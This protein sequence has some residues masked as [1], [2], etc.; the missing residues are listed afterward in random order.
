M[1]GRTNWFEANP[2][3]AKLFVFVLGLLL[4]EGLVRVCV[5]AGLLPYR[6]YPTTPG[7][8]QYWAYIDPVVGVWRP[9]NATWHHQEKCIDATYHTNSIGARDKERSPESTAPRRVLVLGD[10]YLEGYGFN[11][12]A[13]TTN[14]LEDRT[15][16]EFMNFATAGGFGTIQE[17]LLYGSRA[18][19]Y[20]HSD[21]MLFVTP[22]NDF[23]DNDASD[24]PKKIYRPY[25]RKTGEGA[26]EV[27]Y[28]VP[29]EKRYTASRKRSTVIKNKID[30]SIYL[31]N[32][33][34]WATAE[35]KARTETQRRAFREAYYDR[36]DA[37]D[38]AVM[39]YAI[40]QLVKE[41][42]DRRVWL[43]T[44]P[45]D[46]DFYAA[47]DKGYHFPLVDEFK[48]YAAR[49]ANVRYLDLLP[50]FLADAKA[51]GLEFG[52]YTL[53]CDNHWGARGHALVADVVQDWMF[54]GDTEG[55]APP[56]KDKP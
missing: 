53:P 52:D 40:D 49:H 51:K 44:I 14:L 56:A 27:Y 20:Q 36:Y 26:Y 23:K 19:P 48:A 24:S 12:E 17:W 39:F 11:E 42:G 5:F 2:K 32:V 47:R 7:S 34:R 15:G 22:S 29:W 18:K 54:G 38:L 6:E 50:A 43:V 8:P 21:V 35:V 46:T 55:P 41:A 3:K 10:S 37:D 4:L 1:T 25:L 28:T 30:N 33:L 9:A 16:V 13:R 31:L 45:A